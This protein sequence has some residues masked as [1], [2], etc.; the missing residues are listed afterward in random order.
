MLLPRLYSAIKLDSEDVFPIRTP[1]E[2]IREARRL[3][4]PEQITERL[5]QEMRARAAR[6]DDEDF[7]LGVALCCVEVS[8]DAGIGLGAAGEEPEEIFP[9]IDHAPSIAGVILSCERG[10]STVREELERALAAGRRG[11]RA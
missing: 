7:L 11:C 5:T 10:A 4:L 1:D 8:V 6:Q 3:G 2:A 9:F